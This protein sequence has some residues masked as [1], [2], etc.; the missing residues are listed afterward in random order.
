MPEINPKSY[1]SL[2]LSFLLFATALRAQQEQQQDSLPIE[3]VLRETETAFDIKFSYVDE[4]LEDISVPR[5]T[6][7]N[8][9]ELLD[10]LSAQTGLV[11][12]KINER[13]YA[14]ALPSRIDICG[15]IFDNFETN[16]ISGASVEVLGLALNTI[17]DPEGKFILEQ[18]PR[19]ATIRIRHLGYKPKFISAQSLAGSD[20][21]VLPMAVRYEQLEEVVVF[22]ILTAGIKRQGDGSITM[23]VEEFGILPGLSEPDVLQSVQALPGVKSIDETVSDINI[24]GGTNDQNLLLWDGMKMYQSGHFF[25]LISAFNPY[26]TDKVTL[27]KNGTPSRLGE[28]VSGTIM[29]ETTDEIGEQ[30]FGGTG[31]NLISGDAYVH[32]PLNEKTALQFSARRSVTDFLN[33]PTYKQFFNRAFQDTEVQGQQGDEN[34][35]QE[36]DFYFY[37]LSAKVLFNPADGHTLRLSALHINNALQYRETREGES[38]PD[39]STLDQTNISVGLRWNASWSEG[40]RSTVNTYYTRYDLDAQTLTNNGEQQLFQNNLVEETSLRASTY[41]DLSTGLQWENGYQFSEAGITNTAQVTQPPFNSNAKDVLRTH[42]PYSE[43]AYQSPGRKLIASAGLRLS[44]LQNPGDFETLRLEPRMRINAKLLP[45]LR[46]LLLGEYKTQA[47]GQVVDLEQNFLG[48][49]KRRW[50]V[51]DGDQLPITRSQQASGG[52]VYEQGPWYLSG[53][54]FIKEVDGIST[55]T[56]GFQNEGQFD[57]EQGSYQVQGAEFLLN[58]RQHALSSWISYAYNRNEYNFP[59]LDPSRFPNNLDIRHTA[60]LA[61]TYTVSD[62]KLGVGFNYRSGKPYTEPRTDDNGVILDLFPNQIS[63]QAPNSSRLPDYYRADASAIYNFQLSR[64]IKATAGASVLNLLNRRN[65]L[66]AYYRVNNQNEVERV[67]SVSLGL[68]PNVSFRLSF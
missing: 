17:T 37:D 9:E 3:Q 4:A 15:Y 35:S 43:L 2:I 58:Y 50:F 64:G 36:E 49:E 14:V 60:T 33:T 45:R 16:A 31:F 32:L 48:I 30:S 7:G 8:L 47:I 56:Q 44:Y 52:L 27:Y 10:S 11:F 41:L 63:Y 65:V 1:V 42:A 20:C 68:T 46:L 40:F 23:D 25:G 53:E 13:Y 55:L 39:E 18:V 29:M 51:A 22:N 21:K 26:L 34:V 66:N 12:Q 24:R 5:P 28:G 61:F 59:D 67:E 57:N 38:A 62:L 6:S 19:E 54:V